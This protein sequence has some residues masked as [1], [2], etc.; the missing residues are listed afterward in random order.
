MTEQMTSST[1]TLIINRIFTRQ[2]SIAGG[3]KS[4]SSH[5]TILVVSDTSA[6]SWGV[7]SVV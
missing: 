5:K 6:P 3:T 4:N 7:V 2:V 1:V